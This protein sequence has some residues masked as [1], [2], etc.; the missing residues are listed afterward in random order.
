LLNFT[1]FCEFLLRRA[2]NIRQITLTTQQEAGPS[3]KRQLQVRAFRELTDS[4]RVRNVQL[5]VNYS[6]TIHDREIRWAF[7]CSVQF[8]VTFVDSTTVG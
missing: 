4:L 6:P 5:I 8:Y 2:P 3:E 1:R 7:L